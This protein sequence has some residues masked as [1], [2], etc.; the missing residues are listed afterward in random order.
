MWV[1]HR[2]FSLPSSDLLTISIRKNITGLLLNLLEDL[3]DLLE[4]SLRKYL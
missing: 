4:S 2:I 1:V 3:P